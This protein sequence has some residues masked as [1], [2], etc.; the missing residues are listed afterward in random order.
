MHASRFASRRPR[1][2]DTPTYYHFP[3]VLRPRRH[4]HSFGLSLLLLPSVADSFYHQGF[5]LSA[6]SSAYR[7]ALHNYTNGFF[8][9]VLVNYFIHSVET[10]L[11][12]LPRVYPSCPVMRRT[13][14]LT[15]PLLMLVVYMS[16]HHNNASLL[17]MQRSE[18]YKAE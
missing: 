15:D 10:I 1:T 7:V 12:Y 13:M 16:S 3:R 6:S 18:K 11:L 14:T 17:Y 9:F 2:V 5:L 4:M 8:F